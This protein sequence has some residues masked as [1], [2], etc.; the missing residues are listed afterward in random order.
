M[1][2]I[3]VDVAKAS[4]TD[5]PATPL[6][7]MSHASLKL[8]TVIWKCIHRKSVSQMTSPELPETEIMP[9][10]NT[11]ITNASAMARAIMKGILK[12]VE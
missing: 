2:G 4:I 9:H 5:M 8:S 1:C 12:L 7:R 10:P 3:G 11:S 6:K